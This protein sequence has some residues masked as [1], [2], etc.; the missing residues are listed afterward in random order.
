MKHV[1]CSV[2]YF[3]VSAVPLWLRFVWFDWCV[4]E[5]LAFFKRREGQTIWN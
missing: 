2:Y 3:S 1:M 4:R 5:L